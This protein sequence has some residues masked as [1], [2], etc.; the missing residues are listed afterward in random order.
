[1][2]GCV[3]EWKDVHTNNKLV[4]EINS[5]IEHVRERLHAVDEQGQLH[6][7][8]DALLVIWQHSPHESWKAKLLGLPVVK[9]LGR[10]AYNLFAAMLYKWN[11]AKK[12]W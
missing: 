6:V 5:E 4:T 1:M 9:Q 8:F 3:I 12:H 2:Q 7:G 11:L 10:V